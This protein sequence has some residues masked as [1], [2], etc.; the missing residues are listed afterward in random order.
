MRQRTRIAMCQ[1]LQG[2]IAFFGPLQQGLQ[3]RQR[4]LADRT[5]AGDILLPNRI[6]LVP[7]QQGAANRQLILHPGSNPIQCPAQINGGRS[8][9]EKH[10]IGRPKRLVTG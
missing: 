4:M 10:L 7:G 8:S 6:G 1:Q 2:A 9:L 3:Q 5:V